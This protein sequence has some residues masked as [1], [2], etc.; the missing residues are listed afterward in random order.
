L[1]DLPAA[2]RE[3]QERNFILLCCVGS[4]AYYYRYQNLPLAAWTVLVV[5]RGLAAVLAADVVG[6]LAARIPSSSTRRLRE[7]RR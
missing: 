7:H 5:Q 2:S 6:Y 4:G 3:L 1:V